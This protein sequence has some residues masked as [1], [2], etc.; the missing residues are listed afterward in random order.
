MNSPLFFSDTSSVPADWLQRMPIFLE[1]EM[2]FDLKS[3]E[4]KKLAVDI[5]NI[6]EKPFSSFEHFASQVSSRIAVHETYFLR[7]QEQ[8]EWLEN[9]WVPSVIANPDHNGTVR[10]LSA[11]CSTGEEPYSVYAHL[12]PL[13][14][15]QG[16]R[17]QVDAVDVSPTVLDIA[18]KGVYG[19]WSL[20]GVNIDHEKWL[21]LHS[22]VVEVK[23]WV[24]QGVSFSQHN[25][26]KPLIN[27]P[28]YDLILCRNVM[29]YMHMQAVQR[30]YKNLKNVLNANGIIIPGPS[31][32]CPIGLTNFKTCWSNNVRIYTLSMNADEEF[33][34]NEKSFS[35]GMDKEGCAEFNVDGVSTEF[36]AHDCCEKNHKH[37]DIAEL[38]TAC[39]YEDARQKLE[40]NIQLNKLDIRSYV[41]LALLAQ[42]LN[43]IDLAMHACQKA[44]F[45][46]PDS[47]YIVYLM[48]LIKT[49]KYGKSRK[50]NQWIWLEKNLLSYGENEILDYSDNVSAGFLKRVVHAAKQ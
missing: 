27:K 1:Q 21:K 3:V 46:A 24:K 22:R 33:I 48:E 19:L 16:I 36:T 32:P 11:G 45:L 26:I 18:R 41:M 13:F 2:G 6:N 4:L 35:G 29:I 9:V 12:T 28:G 43:D 49:K 15:K 39:C 23:Q 14:E 8:F 17:L 30:I 10:I 31:D 20:R 42:D 7:H 47:I 44:L 5:Q 50:N 37:S 38:I 34:A 40:H 25:L